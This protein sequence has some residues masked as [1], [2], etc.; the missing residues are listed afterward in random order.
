MP[1]ARK[2]GLSVR[3]FIAILSP[4]A[5]RLPTTEIERFERELGVRLPAQYR[6]FLNQCNG[7]REG[8]AGLWFGGPTPEGKSVDAGVATVFGLR[9]TRGGMLR[10][11]RR[12]LEQMVPTATRYL[13]PIFGDGC[14]NTICIG[15]RPPLRGKMFF[16]DH[17]MGPHDPTNPADTA[18][19]FQPLANSF[20]EFIA[21]LKPVKL[22][23]VR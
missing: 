20:R 5:K 2:S 22:P 19:A 12:F 3:A 15:L 9:G 6:A 10:S 7:S 16:F 11:E 13:L 18:D 14:G 17:E 21:G 8:F 1:V 4:R 23:C